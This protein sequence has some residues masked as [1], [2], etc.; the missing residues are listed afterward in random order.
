MNTNLTRRGVLAV[1]AMAV[2]GC[3]GGGDAE[4]TG[5]TVEQRLRERASQAAEAHALATDAYTTV[6]RDTD[7]YGVVTAYQVKHSGGDVHTAKNTH[8]SVCEDIY[9]SGDGDEVVYVETRAVA[10][11][12]NSY[13]EEVDVI[14]A[15]AMLPRGES[16]YINWDN[17]TV[18]DVWGLSEVNL[19]DRVVEDS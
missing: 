8:H 5:D 11:K 1:G 18:D 2:T 14:V 19:Q 13:G 7:G 6:N 4:V 15:S 17:V 9:T 12:I 10:D 3:I 16:R